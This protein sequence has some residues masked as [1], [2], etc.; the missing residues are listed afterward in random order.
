LERRKKVIKVREVFEDYQKR[1]GFVGPRRVGIEIEYP[2]VKKSTFRQFPVQD[3]F[4]FLV[5]QGWSPVFD[6]IFE[7]EL[8]GVEKDER[9]VTTD[10]G[11]GLVEVND[12]PCRSL[13]DV[14]RNYRNFF[15]PFYELFS[16]KGGLV[17]GYGIQP[18][19]KN[20]R[21]VKK[22]RYE[23]IRK[24][25]PSSVDV[26]TLGAASQVHIDVMPE[27]VIPAVNTMNA[28]SGVFIGLFCNSPVWQGRESGK[29]ALRE[30]FWEKFAP[31]RSGIPEMTFFDSE[32]Y[33]NY[34]IDF[35]VLIAKMDG[36][37]VIKQEPFSDF[38]DGLAPKDRFKYFLHHEGSVWWDA[39]PR[40]KFGTIEIRPCCT[41]PHHLFLTIPAFSLG[42]TENIFS[43]QNLVEDHNLNWFLLK[44]KAIALGLNGFD[45]KE[46][47]LVKDVLKMARE[48][49]K[50]RGMK[51]E[52]FLNPVK[53]RFEQKMNPA[54]KALDAF[55]KGG[56][57][58][59]VKLGEIG[60]E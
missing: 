10:A 25:L 15:K 57:P 45:D 1:F 46:I 20:S 34:V 18:I 30:T 38:L 19:S 35:P 27:E 24:V 31:E 16:S 55:R 13:W 56:V 28:L 9:I 3:V 17:L 54:Q 23:T 42:L 21:W 36:S 14:D 7:D 53:R 37:Y 32:H 59:L 49:L 33:L 47:S 60:K 22:G 43:A 58:A 44:E 26:V 52:V 11:I 29:M 8:V 39:R 12:T 48:G 41:Q 4:P 2:V 5:D 51:E 50:S 6:D 40:A